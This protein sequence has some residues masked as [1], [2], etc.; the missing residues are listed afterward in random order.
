TDA[1][2]K[3]MATDPVSAFGGIVS[4]N[5]PVDKEVAQELAKTFL[6]VIIAPG[7]DK[8]ALDI[9]TAKKNVRLLEIPAPPA[10]Q[11][12]D[13]DFRRVAGGLLVQERD[14]GRDD[15]M[16]AKVVTKRA[17]TAEEYQALDFAWRVVKNVKSN[18]I[19]FATRDQ[20]VGVGAGQMSRVDSVHIA[21]MK[22]NLPT[23]GTV[24]ASDA[25]FPFRDGV[26]MA[27]KAGVTAIVQPG[28]SIRD[29]EAIQAADEHGIAMIF[30]GRRHFRH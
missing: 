11:P 23:Q 3:A 16:K 1:Y 12:A 20:L 15:I 17:P 6:E 7:F 5:R 8:N 29:E 2:I 25:F 28:G 26:D 24:L 22:A 10:G 14:P 21:Q 30:T 19:V 9:L 13:L 4:F 27:A 18:A